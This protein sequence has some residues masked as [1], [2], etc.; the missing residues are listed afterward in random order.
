[1][2]PCLPDWGVSLEEGTFLNGPVY[3]LGQRCFIEMPLVMSALM[4]RS[5]GML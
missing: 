3:G 1:M 4:L 5:L 2:P